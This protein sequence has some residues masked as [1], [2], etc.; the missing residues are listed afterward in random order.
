MARLAN[1][2]YPMPDDFYD[3]SRPANEDPQ[4]I[5]LHKLMEES[6]AL[7]DNQIVGGLLSF[8]RGDGHAYYLVTSSRPLVVQWVPYADNWQVE[9]ELIAGL[10]RESIRERLAGQRATAR[11]FSRPAAAEA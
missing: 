8:P 5:E 11:L 4:T 2:P 7:E 9:P 10:T 1:D 6:N 3:P